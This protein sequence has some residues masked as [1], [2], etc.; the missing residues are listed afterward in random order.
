MKPTIKEQLKHR[1]TVLANLHTFA[2]TDAGTTL[3][4]SQVD[5]IE[6]TL[7]L[8]SKNYQTLSHIELVALCARL[9]SSLGILDALRSAEMESERTSDQLKQAIENGDT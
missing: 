8:L 5:Y 4:E 3:Q 7:R 2:E 6:S 1:L 9:E